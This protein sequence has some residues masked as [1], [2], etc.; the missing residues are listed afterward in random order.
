[1]HTAVLIFLIGASC[2]LHLDQNRISI[3]IF[4]AICGFFQFF[5]NKIYY[6]VGSDYYLGAALIDLSIIHFL[7]TISKPTG[8]I[9]I[10]QRACVWLIYMNLFGLI[11]YN[12]YIEHFIY[13]FLCE[14]LFLAVLLFTVFKGGSG[15]IYRNNNL[16]SNFHPHYHTSKIALRT[17][18]KAIRN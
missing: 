17:N 6:L 5:H 1:M 16:H 13:N 15:G 18:K 4:A 3:L 8:L 12:A 7:S 11:I 14:S 9:R 2:M 10:L